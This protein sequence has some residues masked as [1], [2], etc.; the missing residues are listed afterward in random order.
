M[1]RSAVRDKVGRPVSGPPPPPPPPVIDGRFVGPE[2]VVLGLSVPV[3]LEVPGWE[4]LVG[5][6]WLVVWGLF[7]VVR[8]DWAG[9]VWRVDDCGLFCAS[10]MAEKRVRARHVESSSERFAGDRDSRI[11]GI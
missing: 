8:V 1:L 4:G 2:L 6:G 5:C 7:A 9:C 3:I 11:V 10:A